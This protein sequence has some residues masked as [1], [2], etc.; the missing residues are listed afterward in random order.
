MK[1]KTIEEDLKKRD[2]TINSMAIDIINFEEIHQENIIDPCGGLKDIK[3]GIIRH[4]YSNTFVDDPLRMIRAVRFMSQLGFS[5]DQDTC[6]LIRENKSTIKDIPGER[7]SH[8]LFKILGNKRTYFYLDFMDKKLELLE[9]IFPEI[10]PMKDV[11]KCKYHVVDSLTHSILTLKTAEDIIY[12]DSYFEDHLRKEFEKHSE[13]IVGSEHR[14]LELMKLGAFFHDIGKPSA[15]KI[16]H[17]GRT[18]F[19]GHEIIGGEVVRD[20][21]E[22]LRLSSKERDSLSKMVEK[23][24]LPLVLYKNNDVSG[25]ALYGMFSE[26]REDTLDILLI[27]LADIIAT[28]ILLDP[29]EEM[30][31]FKVHIEYVANNYLTRFKEIE[32]ISN[33]VTGR[34]IMEAFHLVEDEQIGFFLEEIRKAIYFGEIGPYK[35]SAFALIFNTVSGTS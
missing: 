10:M 9:E 19:R 24:M 23:H 12:A 21:T 17:N 3:T 32:R 18:R 25:K 6:E 13:E 30:G 7:I 11:G 14:K 16:D 33:I 20:I 35:E 34:D 8:E 31:K 26:T 28:R 5:L 27:S 2:F 29:E 15:E 22:R 4:T 1:S